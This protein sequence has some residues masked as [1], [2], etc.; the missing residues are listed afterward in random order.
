M[1]IILWVINAAFFIQCK[2]LLRS[3]AGHQILSHIP[4]WVDHSGCAREYAIPHIFKL[5]LITFL[6]SL[7][8][9]I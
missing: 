7:C 1:A 5:V 8:K 9:V 2:S 3:P 6:A 4:M